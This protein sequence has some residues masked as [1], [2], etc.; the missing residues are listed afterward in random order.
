MKETP[1]SP[2]NPAP[3][4]QPPTRLTNIRI[5][6]A[7]LG[8]TVLKDGVGVVDGSTLS[9]TGTL[10]G[11]QQ[12]DPQGDYDITAT[13]ANYPDASFSGGQGS[14]NSPWLFDVSG[15]PD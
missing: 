5:V 4:P 3:A 6:V 14:Q 12:F 11:G 8:Q 10:V 2:S 9:C 7:G 1:I 15:Q 13:Q